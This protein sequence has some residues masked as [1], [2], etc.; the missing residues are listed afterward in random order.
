MADIGRFEWSERKAM[1]RSTLL[2][3]ALIAI[4]G[5]GVAPASAADGWKYQVNPNDGHVDAAGWRTP[6]ERC[7]LGDSW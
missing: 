6:F 1:I 7:G 5:I 4:G 2:L 3:A